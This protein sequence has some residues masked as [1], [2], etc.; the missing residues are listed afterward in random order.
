MNENKHAAQGLVCTIIYASARRHRLIALPVDR[1]IIILTYLYNTASPLYMVF[2]SL[3][4]IKHWG[5]FGRCCDWGRNWNKR[6]YLIWFN[7]RPQRFVDIPFRSTVYFFV[8]AKIQLL[9]SLVLPMKQPQLFDGV[10]PWK[11]ILLY[12]PPGTG[13]TTLAKCIASEVDAPF[14]SVSCSNLLS[15]YYGETEKKLTAMF[16]RA[17]ALSMDCLPGMLWM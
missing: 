6:W 9:E 11:S 16:K 1:T 2:I 17:R 4:C 8:E 3:Y 15:S 7:S 12:G 5:R 14:L 10:K 13:K